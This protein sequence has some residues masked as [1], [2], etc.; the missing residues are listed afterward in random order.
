[1]ILVNDY[2]LLRIHNVCA[3]DMK[4]DIS[5]LTNNKNLSIF[6]NNM[7]SNLSQDLDEILIGVT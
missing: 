7:A 6:D 1:M 2:L 4:T 3:V 5:N